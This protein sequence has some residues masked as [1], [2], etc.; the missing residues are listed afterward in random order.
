MYLVSFFL[1][2][3][4]YLS[5]I[6]RG[7]KDEEERNEDTFSWI[8]A[9]EKKQKTEGAGT[10][11]S[12]LLF[13]IIPAEKTTNWNNNVNRSSQRLQS[14]LYAAA[15]QAA[16]RD[17][18]LEESICFRPSSC[19]LYSFIDTGGKQANTGPPNVIVAADMLP[20]LVNQLAT[21]LRQWMLRVEVLVCLVDCTV[22]VGWLEIQTELE[23]L[24]VVD[25][26]VYV[27]MA[28]RVYVYQV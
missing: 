11:L 2:S 20:S 13:F 14:K 18:F 6:I 10:Q 19:L 4:F 21:R 12:R 1:T 3:P 15:T 7:R 22:G 23:A 5:P 8:Y 26:R 28:Y 24:V 25:V 16:E 17:F 27:S 9:E